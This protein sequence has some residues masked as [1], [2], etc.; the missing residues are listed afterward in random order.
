M[1][2]LGIDPAGTAKVPNVDTL[3]HDIIVQLLNK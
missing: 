1:E 3:I 2:M